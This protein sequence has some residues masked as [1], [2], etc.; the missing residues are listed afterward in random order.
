MARSAGLGWQKFGLL[1]PRAEELTRRAHNFLPPKTGLPACYNSDMS[2]WRKLG[3]IVAAT[4]L[5]ILLFSWGLLFSAYQMYATPDSV[6]DALTKSGIYDTFVS[7]V[8]EK[9]ENETQGGEQQIATDQPEVK[10]IIQSAASP[11]YLKT[12]VEGFLDGAYGWIRGETDR[13]L[14]EIDLSGIKAELNNGLVQLA[15]ERLASLPVCGAAPVSTES[16]DPL[17]AEC[18]PPGVDKNAAIAQISAEIDKNFS[19]PVFTQDDIKSRD[20]RTIEEQFSAVRATYSKLVLGLW[21]GAT[22]ILICIAGILLLSSPLRVGLKRVG[23]ILAS[24]GAISV[25][26]ALLAAYVIKQLAKTLTEEGS[27]QSSAFNVVSQLTDGFRGYW[28]WFGVIVLILGVAA[29]VTAMILKN[30]VSV[31][32]DEHS[33]LSSDAKPAQP[34]TE[35]NKP[36]KKI[37]NKK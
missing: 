24:V 18:V 15:H 2:T 29:L 4:L 7:D 23:I 19:D 20:G 31:P 13:L 28:L 21:L 9:V 26:L 12:Q 5:P 17:S 6:K 36:E 3:V 1:A 33:K 14:I 35:I 37:A 32:P 22:V 10:Q 11:E 27:I 34:A 8:L 25:L 30:K 16:F